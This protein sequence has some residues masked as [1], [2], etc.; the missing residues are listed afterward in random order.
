MLPLMIK[1][2]LVTAALMA[3]SLVF[4]EEIVLTALILVTVT[5]TA[6]FLM[7]G[8]ETEEDRLNTIPGDA[9]TV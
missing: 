1:L 3:A 8:P 4:A 9:E 6:V 2:P 7:I 5:V